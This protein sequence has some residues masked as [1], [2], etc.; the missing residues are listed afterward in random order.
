[1]AVV[2]AV[3]VG[4]VADASSSED[5]EGLAA[6]VLRRRPVEEAGLW[7]EGREVLSAKTTAGDLP[8]WRGGSR[9]LP[10]SLPAWPGG[11][12]PS[13]SCIGLRLVLP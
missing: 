10:T 7:P 4:V 8:A 13:L 11:P 3:V 12:A 5:R 1:M 6:A 9:D 2:A